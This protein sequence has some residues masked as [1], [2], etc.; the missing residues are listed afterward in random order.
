MVL[1]EKLLKT[2]KRKLCFAVRYEEVVIGVATV[3]T[4]MEFSMWNIIE[5]T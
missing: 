1:N 3:N 4:G 2:L 5:K